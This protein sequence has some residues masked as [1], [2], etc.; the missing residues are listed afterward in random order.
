MANPFVH[1]ELNTSDVAKA[2]TFYS[3]L[4]K[5]KLE[6]VPMGDMTYTMIQVGDGTGGGLMQHP[7]PGAPSLWIPYVQVEDI[8][9]ATKQATALGATLIRDV[10]EVMGMG[11]LSIFSDPTGATLGL[12]KPKST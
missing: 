11:W 6:D 10:T 12:W 9:A 7:M 1:I 8:A 5:W 2:K 4:F 3:K